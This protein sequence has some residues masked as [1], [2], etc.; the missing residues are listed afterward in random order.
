[1]PRLLRLPGSSSAGS[2]CYSQSISQENQDSS[3]VM[4]H[5]QSWCWKD[6][7]I[8]KSSCALWNR[9]ILSTSVNLW[10]THRRCFN[11]HLMLLAKWRQTVD[12]DIITLF[13]IWRSERNGA[14]ANTDAIRSSRVKSPLNYLTIKEIL[15]FSPQMNHRT[16]FPTVE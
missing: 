5:C 8:T 12:P 4:M 11:L 2:H 9:V 15:S 6:C 14:S 7:K 1:M 3:S 13:A 10:G 16:Y